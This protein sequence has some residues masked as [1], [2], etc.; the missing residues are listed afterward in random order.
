MHSRS[1]LESAQKEIGGRESFAGLLVELAS[2]SSLLVREEVMLARRELREDFEHV[3]SALLKLALGV[4]GALLAAFCLLAAV[5]LAL[6][7]Y[8]Q[9]WQ[10]ALAV[11]VGLAIVAGAIIFN[12]LAQMKQAR[13]M[14]EQTM[15]TIEE[16][17]EWLQEIT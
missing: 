17:K 1:E 8:W 11:G 3:Q 2:Q 13:I 10:A 4:A 14:P 7:Q 12:G 9:P 16:T 5:I 6:S 15:E